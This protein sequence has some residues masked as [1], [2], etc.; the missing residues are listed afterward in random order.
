MVKVSELMQHSSHEQLRIINAI[1][2]AILLEME[3]QI[4]SQQIAQA[5]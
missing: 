2:K 5:A 1:L 3:S 4:E